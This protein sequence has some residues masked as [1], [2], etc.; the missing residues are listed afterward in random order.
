[1]VAKVKIITADSFETL[2]TNVNAY[3]A[4]K[5]AVNVLA[6]QFIPTHSGQNTVLACHVTYQEEE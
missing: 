3:L 6:V 5:D 4:D 1:M 2:E